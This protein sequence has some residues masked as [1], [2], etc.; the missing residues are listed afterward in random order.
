MFKIGAFHIP[1]FILR[2]GELSSDKVSQ[3]IEKRIAYLDELQ[4]PRQG[5]F[6]VNATAELSTIFWMLASF[7]SGR[8]FVPLPPKLTPTEE[9]HYLSFFAKTTPF[10][11][12]EI[13][14]K[15]SFLAPKF[16]PCTSEDTMAFV[17]SSGST[18]KAIPMALSFNNF[19]SQAKAH[20]VHNQ[21]DE[22]DVWLASLPFFHVGGI[23]I[24]TRAMFL[25]QKIAFDGTFDLSKYSYW[26]ESNL[27]TALS[28]VPTQL[29]RLLHV[30]PE[31][32][33]SPSLKMIL[34]GGGPVDSALKELYT[35]K[36]W[37]VIL[38]YGMTETCSQIYTGTSPLPGVTL[39]IS[40]SGEVLIKSPTLSPSLTLDKDGYFASGD[41][42]LIDEKGLLQILGRLKTIINSGGFKIAP[43]EIEATLLK[44][45]QIE[46]A[47]VWGTPHPEW[48]EA[49]TAAFVSKEKIETSNLIDF[50]KVELSSKK[51]PK[52]IFQVN[53]IPKTQNGKIKRDE[54][55]KLSANGGDNRWPRDL[56]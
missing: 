32:H 40:D 14:F 19:F 26:L 43:E 31:I 52:I 41:I 16:S 10:I 51:I 42:G 44:Y 55:I 36:K 24:I 54:L 45:P 33:P 49:L 30:K 37:P 18:S 11:K 27:I 20:Q 50:L 56:K 15:N 34:V 48:G 6:C 13:Q 53:A 38:S 7:L 29:Y 47:A 5:P 2:E 3:E 23:N 21:Q 39:K 8:I 17:F 12:G 35:Q 22:K 4:V 28:L 25:H 1:S 46:E 9:A